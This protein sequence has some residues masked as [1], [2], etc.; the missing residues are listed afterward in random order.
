MLAR[1]RRELKNVKLNGQQPRPLGSL[2]AVPSWKLVLG[3][4]DAASVGRQSFWKVNEQGAG[5]IRAVGQE[6]GEPGL[7]ALG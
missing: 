4:T 7:R 3:V 1:K 6:T 2:T 5:K